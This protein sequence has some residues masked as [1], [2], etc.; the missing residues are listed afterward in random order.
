M[1]QKTKLSFVVKLSLLAKVTFMQN[2]R[3]LL[4]LILRN[5]K[6][7]LYRADKITDPENGEVQY[8]NFLNGLHPTLGSFLHDAV[9][10]SYLSFIQDLFI[11]L[12]VEVTL[13][14]M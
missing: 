6:F 13:A 3:N 8:D 7:W 9:K 2:S 11:A 12:K 5:E 4:N 10:V 1:P 14:F